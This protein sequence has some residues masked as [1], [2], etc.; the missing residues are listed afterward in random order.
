[1]LEI[2]RDDATEQ[3]LAFG[4]MFSSSEAAKAGLILLGNSAEEFNAMLGN[5]RS[6]TGATGVAFEKLNTTSYN[7]QKAINEAKNAA[8]EIGETVL[9]LA[10]PAIEHLSEIISNARAA[11]EN[12]DDEQ[13]KQ[14]VTAIAAVAAISPVAGTIAK[15]TQAV[16]GLASGI[17][18][19]LAHPVVAA[20]A[21]A[22]AA[23][24]GVAIAIHAAN[25]AREAEIDAAARAMTAELA[26]T[27][28]ELA[29]IENARTVAEAMGSARAATDE[30]AASMAYQRGRATDLVAELMNLTNSEGYVAEQD[31]T[32]AQI[33]IDELN[34]A[35]GLEIEMIDGQ[36]Q[37]YD[38]LTDSIYDVINAKTAEALMDRR[39]DDYLDALM[40]EASQLDAVHVAQET[41]NES[42]DAYTEHATEAAR[43]TSYYQRAQYEMTRAEQRDLEDR[44]AAEEEAARIAHENWENA[45]ADL[46]E[47]TAAYADT[48]QTIVNYE[49][50][51]VAAQQGNTEEVIDLMTQRTDAWHDYGDAID[52]ET[53][54][55][56]ND[57]YQEVLHAA[58]YAAQVRENWENGVE[59]YTEQQV[60]EAQQAFEDIRD[61]FSD[62][63]DEAAGIGENF[64]DGLDAGLQSQKNA[65]LATVNGIAR[66]IPNHFR[67]VLNI[68]SPSKVA[69]WIGEMWDRGLIVGQERLA[70]DVVEASQEIAEGMAEAFGAAGH[71]QDEA[72]LAAETAASM[73]LQAGAGAGAGST[74]NNT[75]NSYGGISIVVNGAPGQ[76]VQELADIIMDEMQRAVD[77]REAVYA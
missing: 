12:M 43:L 67:G 25:E 7:V 73:A 18:V 17:S 14:I 71:Q 72:Q 55:S 76:D 56:L 65:L 20:C 44:I 28:A 51:Q 1:M 8:I 68:Q 27:E 77:R 2:I 38:E 39:R 60:A 19:L 41:V 33:I 40:N 64:M 10:A 21:A 57:M 16:S 31:R 61:A 36:I 6:S 59:G 9:T 22:A 49:A 50:A 52:I 75:S 58:E 29:V 63:Y 32:H 48:S 3:G 11:I 69:A 42:F 66:S 53:Q 4:D 45:R 74:T 46:A 24:A 34:R 30:A 47:A 54:R 26:Y 5:V 13:K 23:I 62:A 15:V 70:D 35:Y 37:G